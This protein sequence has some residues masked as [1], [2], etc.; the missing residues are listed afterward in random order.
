MLALIVAILALT[1][2]AAPLLDRLLGRNAGWVLAIPLIVSAVIA[3]RTYQSTTG[4][5]GPYTE[6]HQWMPTLGVDLA[7]RFDGLSLVFL[8]LVLIIGAGV[9]MYSTRYLSP[10]H[11]VGFW[12]FITGFAAAMTLLVLTDDLI[13]FYV[14]WELTTLCSFFLIAMTGGFGGRAPAVRTLLVTVFGGLLLLTATVIMIVTTGTTRLSEVLTSESWDEQPAMLVTVAIL[15]AIAAFTK[16]AQ[17]PFQAWL[18]DSM[19]AISPVSAYLHAAAMVKA[20]I[21]LMLRYSPLFSDLFW[22]QILLIVSGAVTAVFGAMT[23]VKRDDLKEVLAYSTMSQLGLLT[24][25]IGL[26]FEGALTAAIVHTIAHATFKAALF[27]LIGIVD[28]EAGTRRFS[29]LRQMRM[30]LPVTKTLTVITAASMAGIPPLAGFVSKEK[31]IEATLDLPVPDADYTVIFAGVVVITSIMTFVYSARIIMGVF[32]MRR[33]E[34]DAAS[35]EPKEVHEGPFLFWMVPLLLAGVTIVVGLVPQILE[36]PVADAVLAANGA[37][38]EPGLALWHGFNLAL[39]LS[40]LIIVVGALFVRRLDIVRGLLSRSMSPISGLGAVE[41]IRAGIIEAGGYIT[42]LSGTT[43]MRRH[44]AAPMVLLVLIAFVGMLMITDLPE[45]VGDPSR[46]SDWVMTGLIAVGVA[47]AIRANSRLTVIIVVSIVGFSMTLWFYALG[48]ADVATTQ[49]TVEVLTVVVMVLVLHRL[50]SA[51]KS[52]GRSNESLSM[53]LAAGM[54]LATF[55]AIVALTGRREKSDAAEYYLRSAEN[56]TGGSN[57]VNTILVDFRALDTFGEL[58]VLGVA[59]LVIAVLVASRPLSRPH[60]ADLDI[61]SPIAPPRE[62]AVFLKTSLYLIGPIIVGMSAL[63][64][65]RGHYETGGGFVAALVAGAGLML[66]YLAA[67]SDDE[68][69]L[70]VSYSALICAAV[71]VGAVTGMF[72]FLEGSF[73]APFDINLGVTE[74]TSTLIFDLGVYLGVIGLVVASVNLLG[75]ADSRGFSPDSHLGHPH[76]PT[77]G[78]TREHLHRSRRRQREN[79]DGDAGADT[80]EAGP[81]LDEDGDYVFDTVPE[82]P[83][84]SSDATEATDTAE[85]N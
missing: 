31:L 15:V 58:T 55:I 33:K 80:G 22:W 51:F 43:S 64:F 71:T 23:A 56:E 68:G 83:E 69:R 41:S 46:T 67:P 26:A 82:D 6:T 5:S 39:G 48:A 75:T 1:V 66:M 76:R 18:P 29:K 25:T 38:Y 73:L 2:A 16:S 8:M 49:L 54:A 9:V 65:L 17:F 37:E 79:F 63:L 19:A 21:Y 62:N 32:G 42:R 13:V 34:I 4:G 53:A 40:A 59:G 61:E 47:A 35:T 74:I 70:G 77:L 52:E 81:V 12:F 27:M 10:G 78:K 11:N 3:A 36:H 24:F 20:G 44:L 57:I 72:G 60:D 85:R 14:A 84:E 45:I 28:H 30:K 7:F 50:P